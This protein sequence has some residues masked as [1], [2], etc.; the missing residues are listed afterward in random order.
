MPNQ[1]TP[2]LFSHLVDLAALELSAEESDYLLQEL[3]NQLSSID[4]LES[5]PITDETK[6]T[7]HGIPYHKGII[8]PARQDQQKSKRFQDA[9][10]D[11][12]PETDDRFIV[13]PDIPHSDLD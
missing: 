10:L 12:V 3:N 5:I 7:S 2:E 11:Q 4:E 1:I 8:P 9:I 6:I 13:V